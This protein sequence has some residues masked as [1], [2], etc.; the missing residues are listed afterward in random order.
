MAKSQV[1]FLVFLSCFLLITK[2]ELELDPPPIAC[3]DQV[4]TSSEGSCFNCDFNCKNNED[5]SDG[6]CQFGVCYCRICS[7]AIH[8]P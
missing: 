8:K 6:I 4:S 7:T 1:Y 2:M 3:V 5:A